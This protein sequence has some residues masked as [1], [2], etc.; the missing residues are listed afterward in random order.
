[1]IDTLF[2]RPTPQDLAVFLA[3]KFVSY[4]PP[5]LL[6]DSY[7]SRHKSQCL[8]GVKLLPHS[9]AAKFARRVEV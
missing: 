2:P 6:W 1:M 8:S 4:F 3:G 9:E 7:D 5:T